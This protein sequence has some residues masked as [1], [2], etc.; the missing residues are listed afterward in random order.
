MKS[1]IAFLLSLWLALVPELRFLSAQAPDARPL[2]ESSGQFL[3]IPLDSPHGAVKGRKTVTLSAAPF[4]VDDGCGGSTVY[5]PLYDIAGIFGFSVTNLGGGRYRMVSG[6]GAAARDLTLCV[7]STQLIDNQTGRA[8][9]FEGHVGRAVPPVLRDG[10]LLAPDYYLEALPSVVAA[11][12]ASPGLAYASCY[13]DGRMMAGFRLEDDYFL[14]PQA[15][16]QGMETVKT[17]VLVAPDENGGFGLT[18]TWYSNGDVALGVRTGYYTY[19]QP[20]VIHCVT[21]LTG[22]Y[23]TPRGLRV[24]DPVEMCLALYGTLP[25]DSGQIEAGILELT[26]QDGIITSITLRAGS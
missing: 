9:P 15:Q 10:V 23:Q 5:F 6:D 8:L 2:D 12:I 22:R 24:G 7:G 25:N 21:L 18:E 13:D 1:P 26:E 20:S 16:T 19:G 3:Y 11:G 17:R 14:L 4:A